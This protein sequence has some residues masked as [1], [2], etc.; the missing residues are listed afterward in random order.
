MGYYTTWQET[1]IASFQELWF[2]FITLIPELLGALIVLFVGLIIAASLGG[3]AKKLVNR[4]KV[5]SL[6]K[7]IGITRKL[8][9]AGLKLNLASLIGWIVKWFFIIVVLVTVADILGWQQVNLFLQDVAL[10]IPNV[11]VAIAILVIGLLVAQF[12]HDLVEKSVKASGM[13]AGQ[14]VTLA[15]IAKW[16]IIIF[17][18]MAGLMQ[19][20]IAD[21]FI[22]ILFAGLVLMLALALGLA[23]G[24]GGKE[25]A[26]SWLEKKAAEDLRKRE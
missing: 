16:A 23:F 11:L 3:I 8:E 2:K 20:S 18:I 15:N 17:S 9:E 5:D 12:V 14:A 26:R 24:L 25:R 7:K 19:L 10:Y 6:I 22:E 1:F 4:V 21:R 13:L